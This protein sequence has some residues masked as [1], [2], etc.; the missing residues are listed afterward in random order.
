VQWSDTKSA[1]GWLSILL[2]WLVAGIIM[3]LWGIGDW[4]QGIPEGEPNTLVD[5]HISIAASAWLLIWL[6]I[7]W[8]LKSAHPRLAGQSNFTHTS[9]KLLHFFLLIA[10]A[11]M[12]LSGPAMVW[13]AGYPIEVFGWFSIASPIAENSWLNETAG[14]VH[15]LCANIVVVVVL[16]HICGAFKHLMFNDDETF[17]RM[18]VPPADKK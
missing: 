2:H 16:L 1:Y 10:I 14:V 13:S 3:T 9:A 7:I 15:G 6:R 18:L 4:M 8:R 5:L 11:G 12:L 17:I